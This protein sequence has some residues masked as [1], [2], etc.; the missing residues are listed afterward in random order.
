ML[1]KKRVYADIHRTPHFSQSARRREN[2]ISTRGGKGHA[3]GLLRSL[4]AQGEERRRF[5][6]G[7]DLREH[8]FVSL[9]VLLG[10][11]EKRRPPR[12]K[13]LLERRAGLNELCNKDARAGLYSTAEEMKGERVMSL[14]KVMLIG[15]LGHDP[16]IRYTPSGLPVVNFSLAT[17]DF[18]VDGEGKR[19][20][21]T[22]WHRVTIAGKL[23]LTCNE[24]LKK[25]RQ[26]F[27]EGRLRTRRMGE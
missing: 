9:G 3:A 24:Y 8:G 26:V 14:N 7:A 11:H 13:T 22:D 1:R 23:A 16:E 6:Q 20:E 25:G 12:P 21:R 18:H 10:P 27:V 17:D 2:N 5:S 15:Y 19:H 4:R